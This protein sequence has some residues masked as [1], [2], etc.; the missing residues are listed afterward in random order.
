MGLLLNSFAARGFGQ[1]DSELDDQRV[2]LGLGARDVHR[3]VD[4]VELEP[5]LQGLHRA[6]RTGEHVSELITVHRFLLD[7]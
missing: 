4:P 2:T 5:G 3:D 6:V 1:V 7:K